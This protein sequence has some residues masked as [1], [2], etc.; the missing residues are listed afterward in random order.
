MRIK[1]YT[2]YHN[3]RDAAQYWA[4]EGEEHL[5]MDAAEEAV[6]AAGLD[7]SPLDNRD[8]HS[9]AYS[10]CLLPLDPNLLKA[11]IKYHLGKQLEYTC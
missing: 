8:L 1:N 9:L 6:R 7:P 11:C 10:D 2:E 3:Y 5:A 4:E